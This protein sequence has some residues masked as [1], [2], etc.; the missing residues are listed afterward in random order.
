MVWLILLVGDV[1]IK[2]KCSSNEGFQDV[3][4][5]DGWEDLHASPSNRRTE[6]SKTR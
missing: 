2:F 6:V 4:H 1:K 5:G 3:R